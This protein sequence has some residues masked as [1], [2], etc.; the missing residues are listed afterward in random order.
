MKGRVG[1]RTPPDLPG[2]GNGE[3]QAQ[4]I[5]CI[6]HPDNTT[7]SHSIWTSVISVMPLLVLSSHTSGDAVQKRVTVPLKD[8]GR[9]GI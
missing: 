3:L 6:F 8:G 4:G 2:P 7:V 1:G 5:R 9:R